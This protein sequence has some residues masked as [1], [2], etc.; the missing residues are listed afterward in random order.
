MPSHAQDLKENFSRHFSKYGPL[1]HDE[2]AAIHESMLVKEFPRGY[3]LATQGE[4]MR[5]TYFVLSGLVRQYHLNNGEEL[6]TA[7]FTE[8]Q[9][10][11]S[12][13]DSAVPVAS[14][15]FLV[16]AEPT[17]LVAGNEKAAMQLFEKFPRFE[18]VARAILQDAF[19]AQQRTHNEWIAQTPEQRYHTLMQ[20]R[21]AILQR[22]PQYHIA[23]YIGVKPESLSRIRKRIAAQK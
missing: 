19:I 12:P 10:I 18:A 23:S 5:D 8:D 9:W 16:C 15:Y 21:P 13:G 6:T 14:A 22:V 17:L 1:S 11:I 4:I 3:M 7:F 2:K 20:Q